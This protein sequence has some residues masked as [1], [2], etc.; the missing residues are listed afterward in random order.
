MRK[1]TGYNIWYK[2]WLGL[3]EFDKSNLAPTSVSVRHSDSRL[4]A[5]TSYRHRCSQ[6]KNHYY[7]EN[8]EDYFN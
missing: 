6:F 4:T 3:H 2:A 8:C 5:T 1:I 7:E